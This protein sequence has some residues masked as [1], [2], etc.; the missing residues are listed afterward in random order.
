M[1]VVI[2]RARLDDIER[3]VEIFCDGVE[4]QNRFYHLLDLTEGVLDHKLKQIRSAVEDKGE[5]LL[6]WRHGRSEI[7]GYIW[8]IIKRQI[9]TSRVGQINE[10]VVATSH[11][12]KGV[13][14]QLFKSCIEWFRSQNV[15]RVEVNFNVH[16]PEASAFWTQMGLKPFFETR[17]LDV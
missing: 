17:F 5:V 8:G 12:R 14:K 4:S 3:I 1:T 16:N 13:G 15:Q 11:K 10:L 9:D 7:V 2:Q 6:I